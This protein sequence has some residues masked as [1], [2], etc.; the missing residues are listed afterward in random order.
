MPI[1]ALDTTGLNL[2]NRVSSEQHTL[3]EVQ[4]NN[5]GLIIPYYAPFYVDNLVVSKFINGNIVTLDEGVDY[6]L[7]LPFIGASRS[8]GKM[9]YGGIAFTNFT[10]GTPMITYQTLGGSWVADPS[11]VLNQLATL[12][13]NPRVVTWDVVTNVQ[14]TFP[15]INHSLAISDTYGYEDLIS[16]VEQLSQAIINKPVPSKAMIGLGNVPNWLSATDSEVISG[17]ETDKFIS[18]RQLVLLLRS[19]GINI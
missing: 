6:N 4:S 10:E 15:S 7:V 5:S 11:Y 2:A 16:T 3:S 1:Y 19:K 9:L 14:Q 12:L 18:L 8:I 13:Y 17:I